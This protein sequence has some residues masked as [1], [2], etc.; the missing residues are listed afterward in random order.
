MNTNNK[1][2]YEA[3]PSEAWG[4]QFDFFTSYARETK[5]DRVIGCSIRPVFSN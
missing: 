3:S 2:L 1:E 5:V 4:L